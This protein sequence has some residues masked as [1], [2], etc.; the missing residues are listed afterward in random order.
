MNGIRLCRMSARLS[1]LRVLG[2]MVLFAGCGQNEVAPGQPRTT[3]DRQAD[4]EQ[5]A[6]GQERDSSFDEGVVT[7]SSGD[8]SAPAPSAKEPPVA[9]APEQSN[10]PE[11]LV[12]PFDTKTAKEHQ[13]ASADDL[14]VAVEI[15]NSIGMKL[16]LIPSRTRPP[17]SRPASCRLNS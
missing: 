10:E 11:L 14:G 3:E 1:I 13:H 4:T 15:T 12:A 17:V 16:A 2:L 7:G 6:A 9:V 8:L 5:P